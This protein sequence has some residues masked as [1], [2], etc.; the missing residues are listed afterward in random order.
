MS[1]S[2]STVG[3]HRV[4]REGFEKHEKLR[5]QTPGNG[6]DDEGDVLSVHGASPVSYH[7]VLQAP[8]HFLLSLGCVS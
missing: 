2:P 5:G 8:F 4:I 6:H 7:R 1:P 3:G